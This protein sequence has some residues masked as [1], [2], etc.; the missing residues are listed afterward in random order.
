MLPR[1]YYIQLVGAITDS[2]YVTEIRLDFDE[3]TDSECRIR[4]T[5]GLVSGLNLH[6][7][8]YTRTEPSIIPEKYRYHLQSADG[9]MIVRWDNAPHHRGVS[10][11]PNHLH[12]SDDSVHPSS[13]RTLFD[14]LQALVAYIPQ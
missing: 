8:E 9:E 6:V 10:T 3:V 7:S 1:E 5:V 12:K 2:P 13:V 11:F 14:V 4:G